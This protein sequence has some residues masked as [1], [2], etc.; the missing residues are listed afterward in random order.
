MANHPNRSNHT[1]IERIDIHGRILW[2]PRLAPDVAVAVKALLATALA[3]TTTW[4]EAAE[5]I[6]IRGGALVLKVEHHGPQ[7]YRVWSIAARDNT[8]L[9][10]RIAELES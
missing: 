2:L 9:S 5:I 3:D 4:D 7:D 1:L 8:W 10:A 6:D